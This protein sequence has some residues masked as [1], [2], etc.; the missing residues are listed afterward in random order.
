MF[1]NQLQV[2]KQRMQTRQ[3]PSAYLAVRAIA[4]KE[5]V[6][7]L[8]AVCIFLTTRYKNDS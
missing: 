5:G 8:Y 4:A 3:F 2:V 1:I 7:G 6:A